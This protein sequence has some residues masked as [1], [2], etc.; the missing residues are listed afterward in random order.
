MDED[1]DIV[2][3]LCI[4]DAAWDYRFLLLFICHKRPVSGR[5]LPRMAGGELVSPQ[6]GGSI[7]SGMRLMGDV[8]IDLAQIYAEHITPCNGWHQSPP[9]CGRDVQTADSN[10]PVT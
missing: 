1:L 7:V 3:T 10:A 5:Q 4:I 6:L 2:V 9:V 8:V